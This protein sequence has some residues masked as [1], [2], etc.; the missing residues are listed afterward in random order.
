MVG[1]A[2]VALGF[3]PHS[4]WAA[5]VA[6]AAG[7]RALEVLERRRLELVPPDEP[8]AKAP[9]HA[10][11]DLDPAEAEDVVRRSVAS[12]RRVAKREVASVVRALRAQGHEVAACAVPLGSGMPDWTVGQI[13]AV[14]MRMHKAEGELFRDVLLRAGNAAGLRVVGIPERELLARAAQVLRLSP[15]ELAKRLAEAGR[16]VGPPWTKDQKD[17]ALAAWVALRSA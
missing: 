11:E 10:A 13:L 5:L 4:G 3:R 16:A 7:E 6:V 2:E 12:A 17:A 15:S 14:H 1:M 9:Y 8:W